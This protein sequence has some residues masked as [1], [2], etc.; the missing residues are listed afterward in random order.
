MLITKPITTR[1]TIWRL[2][3]PGER[4]LSS[5]NYLRARNG[6]GGGL[7]PNERSDYEDAYHQTNYNWLRHMEI[8]SP[9]RTIT[10][11]PELSEGS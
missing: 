9:R 8:T 3:R 10:Q 11:L 6:G 5:R 7:A 2:L 1:C 4:L